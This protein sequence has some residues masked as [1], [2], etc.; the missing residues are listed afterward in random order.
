MTR[1]Q[2]ENVAKY[3][4]DI[5]KILFATMV[6]GNI[7]DR[8]RFNVLALV[9]GVAVAWISLEWGYALDGTVED[10]E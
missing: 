5:S 9:L 1:R 7:I 6:V 3:C 4:Y 10:P 2:R 8:E